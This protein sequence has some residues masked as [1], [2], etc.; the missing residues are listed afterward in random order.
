MSED[1]YLTSLEDGA[2][3]FEI[4]DKIKLRMSKEFVDTLESGLRILRDY[5][6]ITELKIDAKKV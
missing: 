1:V 5:N 2:V 3:A 6:K 4:K